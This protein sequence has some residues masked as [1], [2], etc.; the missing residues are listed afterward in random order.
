MNSQYLMNNYGT[1]NLSL[2]KGEGRWVW[3]DQ[4]NRY[5][6]AVMGIAVCGLGHSH[7]EIVETIQD[8]ASKLMHCSNLF[9]IPAQ[10]EL[11]TKLARV[12]GMETMF[13]SNSGAEA[14]EAAIKL[15]RLYAREKGI[16]TPKVIVAENCFHGRTMATLSASWGAKV[17]VGFEPLVEDFVHVP[18]NDLEA[19]SALADDK[20]VVAVMVEPVQGES[21]VN[22]PAVDYLQGLRTICDANDWLLILDEIQTG[23][24]RTGSHFACVGQSVA[25]DILT[26]AKGLGNGVPIGTCMAR[27]KAAEL[28]G[29]GSHGSTYGGNPLVCAVANKVFDIIERDGLASNA[30]RLGA[31]IKQALAE[32]LTRLP[33]VKEV[34]NKGLMIAVELTS[35]CGH[36]VEAAKQNGLIINVAG[37]NRIRL[38]PALNMTDEEA[39]ILVDKLCP[40]IE[41]W[42][43]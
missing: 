9:G 39:E 40:V 19:V 20:S 7:P 5:L 24:G 8:Q 34:R 35:D 15:S 36:L 37:G 12:S 3:D 33:Q 23:N 41:N 10:Q 4:G 21:G 14:N 38:V 26:T 27:G 11:A 29:P 25:P 32:R 42:E 1:R 31:N 16:E 2:V 17:R 6:D 30:A 28:F 13:F 18:F 22:I 43:N